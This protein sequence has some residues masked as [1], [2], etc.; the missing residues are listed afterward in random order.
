MAKKVLTPSVLK[1]DYPNLTAWLGKLVYAPKIEYAT[2]YAAWVINNKVGTAPKTSLNE[3]LKLDVQVK[4]LRKI[5][6]DLK[7]K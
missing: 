5:K 6:K 1:K 3:E 4:V 7:A 2:Q